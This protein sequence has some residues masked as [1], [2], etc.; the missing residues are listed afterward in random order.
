MAEV[1]ISTVLRQLGALPKQVEQANRLAISTTARRGRVHVARAVAEELALPRGRI[2]KSIYIRPNGSD[3]II[4]SPDLGLPLQVFQVQ[5]RGRA[6]FGVTIRKPQ[7]QQ[8]YPHAFRPNPKAPTAAA[9]RAMAK[10]G[11]GLF[12]RAP[13]AG[14]YPIK[15]LYGPSVASVFRQRMDALKAEI[16]IIYRD[17]MS[18]Q[19]QR[20]TK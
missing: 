18:R 6:G 10:W 16:E 13:G 9:A 12:E 7:G 14:R 4:G 2:N 11:P 15:Q 19:L 17:E 5:P 8:D 20:L 1:S 3:W